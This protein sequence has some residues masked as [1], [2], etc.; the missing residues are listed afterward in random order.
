MQAHADAIDALMDNG[1]LTLLGE[2]PL[3][4]QLQRITEEHNVDDQLTAMRQQMQIS[5]PTATQKA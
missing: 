1:T 3:T 5:G 2:D 4:P